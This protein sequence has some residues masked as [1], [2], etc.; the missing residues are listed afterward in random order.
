MRK[1]YLATLIVAVVTAIGST[2]C[3]SSYSSSSNMPTINF[4]DYTYSPE[5]TKPTE[6]ETTSKFTV[7]KN[8]SDILRIAELKATCETDI[9][10]CYVDVNSD[11][12]PY[13]VVW[14]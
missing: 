1:R 7:S 12:N 6:S 14:D 9:G 4:D 13:D 11:R 3:I 2:G 5:T 8:Y 10:A